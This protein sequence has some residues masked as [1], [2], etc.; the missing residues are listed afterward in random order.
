MPVRY[1]GI[2]GLGLLDPAERGGMKRMDRTLRDVVSQLTRV[3]TQQQTLYQ[4]ITND[5]GLVRFGDRADR[6]KEYILYVNRVAFMLYFA[7]DED[8]LYAWDGLIW[9]TIGGGGDQLVPY[10]FEDFIGSAFSL[11]ADQSMVFNHWWNYDGTGGAASGIGASTDETDPSAV[12]VV[13]LFSG[14]TIG[15]AAAISNGTT[16]DPTAGSFNMRQNGLRIKFRFR[17]HPTDFN[18]GML[19]LGLTNDAAFPSTGTAAVD[20]II[21]GLW[22]TDESPTFDYA[23]VGEGS[24][25]FF[26]CKRSGVQTY[27]VIPGVVPTGFT[28]FHTVMLEIFNDSAVKCYLDGQLVTQ[29]LTNLPDASTQLYLKAG[30]FTRGNLNPAASQKVYLDRI[31]VDGPDMNR[32]P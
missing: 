30:V 14:A 18:R 21:F 28:G 12:G 10:F 32:E 8:I 16:V 3:S 7:V 2:R 27:N 4:Q 9:V 26:E 15:N 11:N 13:R 19:Y 25:A 5:P 31:V 22:A 20:E 6:P 29:L 24:I 17:V 1:R 23:T